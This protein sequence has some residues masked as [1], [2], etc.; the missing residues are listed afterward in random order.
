MKRQKPQVSS[1]SASNEVEGLP[2]EGSKHVRLP[3]GQGLAAGQ[4]VDSAWLTVDHHC[5]TLL[6]GAAMLTA[7]SADASAEVP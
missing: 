2:V 1:S 6:T 4:A 3:A 7:T 5:V